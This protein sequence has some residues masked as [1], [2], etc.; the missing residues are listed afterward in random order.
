MRRRYADGR[1]A[2]REYAPIAPHLPVVDSPEPWR[3]TM[4]GVGLPG[5]ILAA[6]LL[7]IGREPP[8]GASNGSGDATGQETLDAHLRR[9]GNFY[10]RALIGLAAMMMNMAS[11]AIWAPTFLV[12]RFELDQITSGYWI[13]GA[14]L[15][16]GIMG[17]MLLPWMIRARIRNGQ[18]DAVVTLVL[19]TMAGAM[20]CAAVAGMGISLPVTLLGFGGFMFLVGATGTMPTL[21]VQLYVPAHM[22]GRCSAA[23]FFTIY[24]MSFGLAPVLVPMIAGRLGDESAGIGHAIG[25]L[26]VLSGVVAILL[27]GSTRRAFRAA[28]RSFLA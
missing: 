14:S 2:L 6:L 1:L 7:I 27:F 24:L 15:F 21:M 20:V 8:R 28:E 22:R 16:G 13:G 5:L 19:G 23:V 11:I 18:I 9:R 3:L 26:S 10:L 12:R 17:T 25:I 4:I